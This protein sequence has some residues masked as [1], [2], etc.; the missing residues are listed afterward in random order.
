MRTLSLQKVDFSIHQ[1]GKLTI[2]HFTIRGFNPTCMNWMIIAR[3]LFSTPEF[4]G[5]DIHVTPIGGSIGVY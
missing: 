2:I 5:H 1:S 3:A 4:S